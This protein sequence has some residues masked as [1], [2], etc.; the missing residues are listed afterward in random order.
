[1]RTRAFVAVAALMPSLANAAEPVHLAPSTPWDIDYAENSC[2]LIRH[3]GQGDDLTIL[4]FESEAPGA[5]DML[6]VGKPVGTPSDQ[7]PAKFVPLQSKPMR[8][9]VGQSTDKG[10]PMALFSTVRLL[11]DEAA[12]AEEKEDHRRD[13]S[14]VR[15]RPVSVAEQAAKKAMR[16]NFVTN[17]T[18]I[19]ID[20]RRDRPIILDTGSLG[21]PIKLFDQCS[22]N[23]LRDWGVDPDLEDKIVKPV[24]APDPSRWFSSD[25]YPSGMQSS[26]QESVVK[27]RVLVDA[28]GRVTK[29]TSVSHFQAPEF[30]QI[31]C[32]KFTARA[33]FA[34]AEL[35]DG[36]KVPSYYVNKVAF[37][38]R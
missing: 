17:T 33:H 22:R 30:D 23:S 21:D 5:L 1:M 11:P 34:P 31:T 4:V 29:C 25:D 18:A 14:S 9:D 6:V 15:P 36:T 37:R 26:G 16:Q 38:L 20:P 24:W 10:L 12:A 19:E 3:F 2:R 28:T 27:V 35:A 13:M 7:V 8:G 32:A